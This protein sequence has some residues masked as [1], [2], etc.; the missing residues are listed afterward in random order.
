LTFVNAIFL[1][2]MFLAGVGWMSE[3]SMMT[4]SEHWRMA[5]PLF[6]VW[7][8]MIACITFFLMRKFFLRK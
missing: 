7:C 2:L 4:W 1:P 6:I 5:Y 3:W 8:V